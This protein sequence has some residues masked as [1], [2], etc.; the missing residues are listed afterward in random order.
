MGGDVVHPVLH[1]AA[2]AYGF[3]FLHP[4]ENGNGRIHRLL[5][6]NILA[7]RDFT[8]EGLMFPVS[9]AMLKNPGEYGASLEAFSKLLMP[10]VEFELDQEG[11]MTVLNDTVV[12]YRYIDMTS[13]AEALFGFIEKTIETELVVLTQGLLD[14][15]VYQ[16]AKGKF[17][18]LR[19][20]RDSCW[21]R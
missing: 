15:I 7:R 1:A 14:G 6:H 8:P 4:F 9:A 10:F 13:Q 16:A 12:W 19:P 17:Q 20:V 21:L 3:V 18:G 5:I 2:V 11:R